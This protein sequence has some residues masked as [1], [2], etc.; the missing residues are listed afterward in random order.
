L[1]YGEPVRK[2]SADTLVVVADVQQPVAL[3]Y[4]WYSYTAE[5]S[6]NP[7][8]VSG[9]HVQRVGQLYESVPGGDEVGY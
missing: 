2:N 6:A 1:S 9:G 4:Q 8:P 3:S 5:T 7:T